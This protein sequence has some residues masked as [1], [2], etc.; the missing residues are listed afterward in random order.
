LAEGGRSLES[1]SPKQSVARVAKSGKDVTLSIEFSIKS[2]GVNLYV[3]MSYAQAMNSLRRG[4]KT[5]E[6]NPNTA[7]SLQG[8][9][10]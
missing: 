9:H 4:Y 8:A 10:C 3:G 1:A 6:P 2:G 7:G 5:K